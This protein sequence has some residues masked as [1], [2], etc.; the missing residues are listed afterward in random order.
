MLFFPFGSVTFEAPRRI[1]GSTDFDLKPFP[2]P[3]HPATQITQP[4]LL[5]TKFFVSRQLPVHFTRVATKPRS[6]KMYYH[7]TPPLPQSNRHH[8][9]RPQ[10]FA[11]FS[12]LLVEHAEI[13]WSL[14]AVDMDRVLSEQSP[15][16]WDSFPLFQILNDYLRTDGEC[17]VV[18]RHECSSRHFATRPSRIISLLCLC[19]GH[20]C[21]TIDIIVF[22]L[23]I[24]HSPS[25]VDVVDIESST[26]YNSS[27]CTS[28][29]FLT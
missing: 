26:W 8:S 16:T 11:W 14:F 13:F 24:H 28:Y 17:G 21:R 22:V 4:R 5:A 12:D 19:H 29:D 6:L 25:C 18:M 7:P 27:P 9:T 3:P 10:A 23:F 1:L 15:D 2:P 20:E